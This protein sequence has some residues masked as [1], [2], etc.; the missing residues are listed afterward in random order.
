MAEQP[1]PNACAHCGIDRDEHMRPIADA[2]GWH[3]WTEPTDE[4][5]KA[6]LLAR[7][8]SQERVRRWLE[9]YD[10]LVSGGGLDGTAVHTA[11]GVPLLLADLRALV[12]GGDC[13]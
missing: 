4:Q 13:D 6:R 2:L 10:L 8:N 12:A 11:N 1:A 9:Q 5:R 3:G 7:H